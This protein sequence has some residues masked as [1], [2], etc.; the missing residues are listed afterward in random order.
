MDRFVSVIVPTYRDVEALDLILEAL[1]RQTYRHFEV[2]IAEDDESPEL[3]QY[4]SQMPYALN[5]KHVTHPDEGNR[6]AVVMNKAL[7][8][9]SGEYII[10]IDGDTI[11][12]STFVQSHVLLSEPR[13]VL[14]GRRVNLGEAVSNDLRRR[15]VSAKELERHFLRRIVYLH[16]GGT[17]H[18]EQGLRLHPLVPAN[19]IVNRFDDNIHILGSNFSCW[20]EDIFAINGFDEA[21]V[22]GSKDDVD[23]EWRFVD[24]GC[25]LKSCKYAA[26]L[27]H[28]DHPRSDRTAEEAIA[29]RQM[30][31]NRRAGK[32]VCD[33]GIR[34]ERDA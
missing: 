8:E 34:Q 26:N 18:Y 4:L 29:K 6:K 32:Y 20:R 9:C 11:P 12:F 16:R 23:L 17:K 15:R 22:G 19:R 5:I 7:P 14:C 13:T 10:F 24:S 31:A 3:R 2:V 21:I 25:R 27:F 1:S 30:E 33:K 28:L